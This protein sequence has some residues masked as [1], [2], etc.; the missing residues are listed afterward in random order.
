MFRTDGHEIAPQKISL[1]PTTQEKVS[2]LEALSIPEIYKQ[3][4]DEE[5]RTLRKVSG[6]IPVT[7]YGLCVVEFAERAAYHGC[8]QVFSNFIEFPLPKGGNGAGATPPGTQET[9]GALGRGE[10]TTFALLVLFVILASVIPILGAIIADTKL[11]RYNTICIGILISGLAHVTFVFGALPSVLQAGNGLAP[12]LV[13][14]I[15]LAFGA[16]K[17]L[18]VPIFDGIARDRSLISTQVY[19]NQICLRLSS[20]S[21]SINLRTLP[22]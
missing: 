17:L 9:A 6:R 20:I 12:F 10:Q 15:V 3:P 18:Y 5:L 7:A 19:L 2:Y 11:G 14:I 4:V 22:N 13:G 1:S 16:G 21:I 8:S